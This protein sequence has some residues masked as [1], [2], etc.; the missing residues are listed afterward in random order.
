MNWK[1]YYSIYD[2]NAN[3]NLMKENVVQINGGIT[4]NVNV[5]KKHHISEKFGILLDEVTK[6]VNI[7][8]VSKA[9]QWLRVIH[10]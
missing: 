6:M 4:I 10:L 7:Y 1:H 3:V 9:I 5:S 2:A 8:Q